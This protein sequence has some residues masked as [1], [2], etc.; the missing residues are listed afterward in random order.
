M[1]RKG[2]LL[3][4]KFNE[5][6]ISTLAM[7]ASLYLAAIVD[8]IMVGNIL[9]G[10]ALAAV[11]LTS[12]VVFIK[13]IVFSIFIYGGNTLAAMYKGK[14]DNENADK[15][16]TFSLLFGVIAST[17]LMTA[18]ILTAQPTAALFSQGGQ[19]CEDVQGTS[20]VCVI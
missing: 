16:F 8:N 3:R 12:P 4:Q 15:A 13:N 2:T 9:G 10:N 17:V 6:L 14:R 18:G 1:R 7:S 20:Y 5:Y 11:N 19:F